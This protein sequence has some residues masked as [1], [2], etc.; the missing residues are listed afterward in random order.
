MNKI[1]VVGSSNF[2]MIAKVERLPVPGETIGG[3]ELHTS[4]G[5][6]GANQAVAAARLGGEVSFVT[7]VGD[8]NTG[9]QLLRD[10]QNEGMNIES[11]ITEKG[12]PTGTA[13]IFVDVNGENCI[14]VAPGANNKLSVAD[15][16]QLELVISKADVIVIQL[17]IPYDTVQHL[18]KL[19]GK[20][21]KKILLNPAPARLLDTDVLKSVKYLVLNETEAEIISGIGL[22]AGNIHDVCKTLKEMGPENIILTLGEKGSYVYNENIQQYVNTIKVGTID[23][24]AAGDTFCGALAVSLV[25]NH[26][27]ISSV[28]FA[29]VA[30]AISTTRMGAQN[31]IPTKEE[32]NQFL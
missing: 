6:K 20:L 26:D 10:Y 30:A 19:A 16:D 31:S 25:K 8:D 7:K 1:L 2:D 24:T 4:N 9:Q 15:I 28:K 5:G 18:C 21:Q 23:T 11:A 32:V 12:V 14:V 3:A 29:S 13:L 17:E 27:L 22:T